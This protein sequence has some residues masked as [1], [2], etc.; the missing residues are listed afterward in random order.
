[1]IN[2]KTRIISQKIEESLLGLIVGDA[3]GVP[4][5]FFSRKQLAEDP[6]LNMREFGTYHQ[7]EGTW[8]DDSTMMLITLEVLLAQYDLTEMMKGFD[9]WLTYAYM[10]PHSEVF[11]VGETTRLAIYNYKSGEPFENWGL[12][13]VRSNGNGSLMRMLPLSLFVA[14]EPVSEIIKK[15]FDVSALTHA[16]DRSKLCCGYFSLLIKALLNEYT[17]IDAMEYATTEIASFVSRDEYEHLKRILSGAIIN[18]PVDN[19]NS[20]GYVI[21]T[22]E[23]SLWCCHNSSSFSEAVLKAVNLGDDSDTTGAVTGALAGLMYLTDSRRD[24][25]VSQ[26]AKCDMIKSLI[27]QFVLLVCNEQMQSNQ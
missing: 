14:N 4:V 15:T 9:Q 24:E 12:Q 26:L 16:H 19:I 11:D 8:S 20:S 13:D 6:V 22:L 2:E 7:P 3:L 17:L 25:W 27:K 1:M 10:T 21:S 18:V 5:E 23:A